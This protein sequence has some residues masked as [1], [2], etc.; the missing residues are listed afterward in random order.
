MRGTGPLRGVFRFEDEPLYWQQATKDFDNKVPRF[1][2]KDEAVAFTK[3]YCQRPAGLEPGFQH[4]ISLLTSWTQIETILI[5]KIHEYNRQWAVSLPENVNLEENRYFNK[6]ETHDQQIPS[7]VLMDY[8]RSRLD[9][10]C[11]EFIVPISSTMNTLHYLFY[12]M[13]CGIFVMIRNNQLVVF[14]PFSNKDFTNTWNGSPEVDSRDGT[15]SSYYAEKEKYYRRE[16]VIDKS[17]WW[18]NGNIIC[19]ELDDQGWGDH[20]CFQLKDMIAETCTQRTI[21]DCEFFVNKRDYPQLKYNKIMEQPVEPYGF[22]FNNN[23]RDPSQDIPLAD[24]LY[25]SYAPIL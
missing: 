8:V 19:N 25:G 18:A 9:L 3:Q 17:Q 6:T 15:L 2:G 5:P 11:H 21:P 4:S 24:N 7:S 23:D 22:I 14:C 16:K 12:H 1:D 20:F 13:K 10:K